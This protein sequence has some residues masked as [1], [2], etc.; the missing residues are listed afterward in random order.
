M[1]GVLV[2]LCIVLPLDS[3]HVSNLNVKIGMI[4][5]I[6]ECLSALLLQVSSVTTHHSGDDKDDNKGKGGKEYDEDDV[7]GGE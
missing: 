4:F 3:P 2:L 6:K 5:G 7:V 1:A